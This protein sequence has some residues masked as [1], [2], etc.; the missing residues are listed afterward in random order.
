MKTVYPDKPA[1]DFNEWIKYI[2]RQLRYY[3]FVEKINNNEVKITKHN[4]L[5]EIK[6]YKWE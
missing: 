2:H 3:H 1:K 5:E 6:K 4:F